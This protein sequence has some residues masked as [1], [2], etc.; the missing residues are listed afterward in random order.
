[1]KIAFEL[2]ISLYELVIAPYDGELRAPWFFSGYPRKQHRRI[3]GRG[4]AQVELF[5]AS[6][7]VL[8]AV[9]AAV[10]ALARRWIRLLAGG[11]DEAS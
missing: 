11:T 2:C 10:A 6:A 7:L 1:M 4:E 3:L 5:G 8:E 9:E